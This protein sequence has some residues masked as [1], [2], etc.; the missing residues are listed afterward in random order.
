MFRCLAA[1]PSVLTSERNL[2]EPSEQIARNAV[3][4][5]VLRTSH[6]LAATQHFA[7]SETEAHIRLVYGYVP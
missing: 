5:A 1:R 4:S 6:H 2:L 3:P 7:P